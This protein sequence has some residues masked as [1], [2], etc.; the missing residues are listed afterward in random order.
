MYDGHIVGEFVEPTLDDEEAMLAGVLG[1][2]AAPQATA[3]SME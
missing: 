1:R 3:G 2:G